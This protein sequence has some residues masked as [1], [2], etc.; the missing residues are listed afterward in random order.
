MPT[1]CPPSGLTRS[2]PGMPAAVL[3]VDSLPFLRLGLP[4][5]RWRDPVILESLLG[6]LLGPLQ[7]GMPV[8]K[9]SALGRRVIEPIVAV[10]TGR[11]CSLADLCAGQTGFIC[12]VADEVAPATA[13]RMVDLGF[14]PGC[15]VQVLRRAPMAD[16][17][18]FRVAGYEIALRRAQARCIQV[19]AVP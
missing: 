4:H 2:R 12:D 17:V 19:V 9:L 13:R 1:K 6:S 15:E 16:P 18:M 7:Q 3:V 5:R 8:S 11:R 10:P 14:A